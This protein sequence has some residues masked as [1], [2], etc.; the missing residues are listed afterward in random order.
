MDIIDLRHAFI[1]LLLLVLVKFMFS[2]Q[3]ESWKGKGGLPQK[4][5]Y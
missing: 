4:L 1:K 3:H 5:E 2:K